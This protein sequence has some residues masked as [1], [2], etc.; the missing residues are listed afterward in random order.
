MLSASVDPEILDDFFEDDE[1]FA[2]ACFGIKLRGALLAS[3]LLGLR[4]FPPAMRARLLT[5]RSAD[6]VARLGG[7]QDVGE[8]NEVSYVTVFT[9]LSHHS[10]TN[11]T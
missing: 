11:C 2:V 6:G 8:C 10:V 3:R 5:R 7:I 9:V 4:S 1:A